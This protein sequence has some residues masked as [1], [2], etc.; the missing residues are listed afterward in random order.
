MQPINL[1]L[2]NLNIL[3]L[4]PNMESLARLCVNFYLMLRNM[5]HRMFTG[6]IEGLGE[7]KYVTTTNNKNTG[8]S[9]RIRI[10]LGRLSKGLKTGSS[11][12][13]NGACLTITRIRNHEADFDVIDETAKRTCLSHLKIGDKVNIERSLRLGD[14]LEGHLVL[15]HIEGTGR[16]DKILRS[17]AETRIWIKVE[18]IKLLNSIIPKGSIAIDGVSLTVADMTYDKIS[19]ALI[20]HTLA[21]TTLGSKTKG[22]CVNMET[23]LLGKYITKGLPKN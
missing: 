6:I 23:D 21:H 20:P 22:N 13:V 17:E 1:T 19:L 12:S 7:V 5:E 10:A 9:I 16:I 4:Y 11:V 18:N 14:R 2:G 8:S 15:G 3:S